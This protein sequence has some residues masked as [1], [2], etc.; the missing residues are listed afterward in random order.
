MDRDEI[1]NEVYHNPTL[2]NND[3]ISYLY[4]NNRLNI[5]F[6]YLFILQVL[7]LG[8]EQLIICR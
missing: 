3:L 8:K 6:I 1:Y 7:N 4:I 5:H 2:F